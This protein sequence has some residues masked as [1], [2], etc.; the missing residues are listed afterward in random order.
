MY[1]LRITLLAGALAGLLL[2][3]T[4]YADTSAAGVPVPTGTEAL[5][6]NPLYRSGRLTVPCGIQPEDSSGFAAA[7][8]H[9]TAMLN[10]LN[11][12]WSAQLKKVGLPFRSP[13]IRFIA[14][15]TRVCG[16]AW[17][18]GVAGLYC[19]GERLLVILVDE[20]ATEDPAD[21]VTLHI[22]AHEY[23]H[24]IQN[25]TG[26]S[27][28]YE[29]MPTRTK[30]QALTQSRRL[31]LQ[32]DCL[33]AAFLRSIWASQEYQDEDWQEVLDLFQESGDEAFGKERSH[34]NGKN[35][36]AWLRKGFAAASPAACNTWTAPASRIA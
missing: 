6:R 30:A 29:D 7:K 3:G 34:G 16:S 14:K 15:P 25:L 18:E 13:K 12:S 8:K 23:A 35:K 32:A 19:G 27:A 22:L 24:H 4:A 31:E 10:C 28:S 36:V 33:G 11:A 9:L 5:T 20:D 17:D 21:P 2:T 26:I 1:T